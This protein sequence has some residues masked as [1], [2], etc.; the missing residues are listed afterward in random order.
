MGWTVETV[1][2]VEAEIKALPA[3]LS[4]RLIRLL[5]PT[6]RYHPILSTTVV[7]TSAARASVLSRAANSPL[8]RCAPHPSD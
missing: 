8:D 6:P 2:A 3:K 4:A 5:V 7:R 1:A